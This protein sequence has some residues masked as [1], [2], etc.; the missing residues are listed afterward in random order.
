MSVVEFDRVTKVFRGHGV[1][2]TAVSDVSFSLAAGE[3]LGLIGESG[4][5]KSTIAKLILGL[6]TATSGTILLDGHALG[7]PPRRRTDRLAHAKRVQIVFQDPY[8]SLNPRLTVGAAVE[9]V[10]H[11]HGHGWVESRSR[12]RAL[13]AEVGLGEREAGARPDQLSGGQR[14]RAAIAKAI[15]VSP[16]LL[17]LD[18]AVAALDVSVQAQVL[19][20][21]NELRAAEGMSYLFIT[22]NLAVVQ[23]VTDRSVVLCTGEVVESGDTR[24]LL[25]QPKHPYVQG[26]L[27]SVPGRVG[28]RRMVSAD[29]AAARV[30]II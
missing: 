4:S 28:A 25:S 22:H 1:E 30:S 27:D 26:L 9:R 15:A 21:L 18:E 3:S 7:D 23:Y 8:L 5:G 20:L 12:A 13:L 11:L 10:L 2:H 19:N 6:E 17:I 24:T 16:R 29:R 14:Q